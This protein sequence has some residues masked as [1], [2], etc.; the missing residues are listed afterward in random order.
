MGVLF[1]L[2]LFL[3]AAAL[4]GGIAGAIVGGGREDRPLWQNIVIGIVGWAVA[5][6]IL[7]AMTG[8]GLEEVTLGNAFL[9]LAASVVFVLL[10]EWWAGRQGTAGQKPK[11]G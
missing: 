5:A 7:E 9:A 11:S 6:G 4:T 10:D 3:P 1:A 2:I 8:D